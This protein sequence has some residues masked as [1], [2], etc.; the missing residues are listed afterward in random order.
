MARTNTLLYAFNRGIISALGLARV[1]LERIALSAETMVNWMPRNLG[2]MMLRPGNAYLG[3]SASN[4]KARHIPFVYS[5]S[6][7]AIVELT[8][9]LM[10]VWVSDALVTRV[11]V[12][13]AVTDGGF[14][15]ANHHECSLD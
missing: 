10:R 14:V 9:G 15:D 13:S 7:K 4:N 12:T 8:T 1:D 11:A 5:S 2:S 3:T 6:D